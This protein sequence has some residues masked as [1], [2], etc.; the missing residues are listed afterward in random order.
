MS[1]YSSSDAEARPIGLDFSAV[2]RQ[3]YLWVAL[4]L[5]VC[6]GVSYLVGNAALSAAASMTGSIRDSVLFNPVVM[7]VSVIA[8]LILAFTIQPI[9]MRANLGVGSAVY[10]LFAG[11]FGFM[12]SYI[13]LVY[14]PGTIATAFVASAGMFGAMSIVGYTTK[15]DLSRLG[16]VLIMALIGLFIATI[17]NIFLRLEMLFWLIN[18]AGV[19]IFAGLTAYDTQWIKNNAQTVAM[20]WNRE[21]VGR[22][23]LVGALHLFLDF[24]NLFM[25][26]L[27]IM[28]G[29]S[30]D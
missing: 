30:R 24:V 17:L 4:G 22:L 19:V 7:I 12:I 5:V 3:V 26:I 2:M 28:G 20:S 25:F 10:L 1:F 9:I 13:F 29:S 15:M 8:Y 27:R 6:F 21:A 16:N 11:L 14:K 18:Y 23:A